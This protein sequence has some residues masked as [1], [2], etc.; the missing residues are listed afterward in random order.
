M[1][2]VGNKKY[3]SLEEAARFLDEP[4]ERVRSWIGKGSLP[5]RLV[6]GEPMIP[7]IP[8][9]DFYHDHLLI[10]RRQRQREASQT[11]RALETPAQ[12]EQQAKQVGST[13]PR[14]AE[15]QARTLEENAYYYT[16]AQVAEMLA[17]D[18]LEVNQL[19]RRGDLP[20][21]SVDKHRWLFAKD[22]EDLVRQKYGPGRLVN[23]P[24]PRLVQKL[25]KQE[26]KNIEPNA[27]R[28][29]RK[30]TDNEPESKIEPSAESKTHYTVDEAAKKL[31]RSHHEVWRMAFLGELRVETVGDQR[32]FFKRSVDDL[33]RN[34]KFSASG[35]RSTNA[36]KQEARPPVSPTEGGYYSAEEVADK[37]GKDVD[38]VWHM[39]YVGK[40][41]IQK[42]GRK[43]V[44]SKQ[45]VDDLANRRA[46]TLEGTGSSSSTR[47]GEPTVDASGHYKVCTKCGVEKQIDAF[48][49]HPTSKDGLQSNCRDC[50]KVRSRE[51]Y[52]QNRGNARDRQRQ[53]ISEQREGSSNQTIN[54]SEAEDREEA[55]RTVERYYYT[56]AQAQLVLGKTFYKFNREKLPIVTIDDRLW[57]LAEVVD[58]L[59]RRKFGERKLHNA[60][61]PQRI[62]TPSKEGLE[63]EDQAPAS[64][65]A[66][67][68]SED[69]SPAD[70]AVAPT[71]ATRSAGELESADQASPTREASSVSRKTTAER[72][73]EGRRRVTEAA[74]RLG[75]SINEVRQMVAAGQL[76]PDLE[77]GRLVPPYQGSSDPG[78]DR[79]A[80]KKSTPSRPALSTTQELEEKVKVFRDE[81]RTA[82]EEN[83]HLSEELKLERAEHS[84]NV[85][86][87]QQEI[88][89]LEAELENICRD[90]AILSEALQED[91]EEERSR[92]TDSERRAE[93]LQDRLDE[94]IARKRLSEESP[95][96][97]PPDENFY[98]RFRAG[99]RGMVESFKDSGSE[100][101]EL[102][103]YE[104][105]LA[106]LHSDLEEERK[107]R[108]GT[109]SRLE[110]SEAEKQ[111]LEEAL[112]LEKEKTRRLE[113]EKQTLDE[114][115]RL[116]GSAGAEEP[117][118][119]DKETIPENVT[120]D[121]T[122]G[123][124]LL[125][126]PFGQVSFLP[127]FPLNE[128]EV[129][130]LRLIAKEDELTGEQIQKQMGRRRAHPDFEYLLER[131]A[132]EGVKLVEEVS[133]DRYRF[134]PTA[135]QND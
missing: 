107:G 21:I 30:R 102:E 5:T 111:T 117:P 41:E 53:R 19:V 103:E 51:R 130:L 68:K 23:A 17:T 7:A 124:L 114:V 37:L 60:P 52:Q 101:H 42:V 33:L 15:P 64:S 85:S 10:K 14:Q 56:P 88:D 71:T 76:V 6:D 121:E 128:Q 36:P 92:R 96:D 74:Q 65:K 38:D 46:G 16:P 116:L 44:F 122:S 40:L 43:R 113:A 35:N 106:A 29:A 50:N 94:E 70:T 61:K 67:R 80:Q 91:L 47:E 135:L 126:T 105:R 83:E 27:S 134:N 84:R 63:A 129:A 100:Q 98:G 112:S 104:E 13:T 118:K 90:H 125:K 22:V 59:Y 62:K 133:E 31:G 20:A 109:Q 34:K 66:L 11:R 45:V 54:V 1:K 58:D 8:L 77:S 81:L 18:L 49:R 131:L 57:I 75:K 3:Y 99:V 93:E 123:E 86:D 87:A 127:P 97:T 55:S 2:S 69:R 4:I 28:A 132:D 24:K 73:E 48:N 26:T 9:N 72:A 108:H 110:E 89:Q 95:E 12:R 39:V 119:L 79:I 78:G 32:M 82:K 120:E 115:K 25:E